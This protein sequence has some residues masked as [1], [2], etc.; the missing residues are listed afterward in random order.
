MDFVMA[1]SQNVVCINAR[2]VSSVIMLFH[3]CP[4]IENENN[5]NNNVFFM[6]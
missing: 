6:F 1:T 5:I 3:N 2:K 4:T